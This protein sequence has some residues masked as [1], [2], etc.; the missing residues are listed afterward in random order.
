M[1]HA[2]PDGNSPEPDKTTAR[3]LAAPPAAPRMPVWA[4]APYTGEP[5]DTEQCLESW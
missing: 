4:V 2:T 3:T 1:D 5:D